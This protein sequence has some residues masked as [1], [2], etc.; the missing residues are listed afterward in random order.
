MELRDLKYVDI[1]KLSDNLT[2]NPLTSELKSKS[3]EIDSLKNEVNM[4]KAI[5]E[6]VFVNPLNQQ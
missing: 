3:L 6:K 1:M 5:N 4:L 2:N